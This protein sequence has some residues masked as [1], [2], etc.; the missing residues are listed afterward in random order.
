[1]QVKDVMTRHVETAG[2]D[3]PITAIAKTMR[4]HDIGLLPVCDGSR[5][6]GMLSDRDI[7]IRAMANNLH[8]EQLRCRDIMTRR[9]VYCFEDHDLDDARK[10]MQ[11]HKIRRLPVLNRQRNLVG[12]VAL[13]DIALG[14]GDSKSSG[15]ALQEVSIPDAPKPLPGQKRE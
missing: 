9:V 13:S 7:A 14:S 12:I 6:V 15:I 8:P 2:T 1:M 3:S 11:E 4:S 5:V 10:L